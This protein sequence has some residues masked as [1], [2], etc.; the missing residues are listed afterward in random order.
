MRVDRISGRKER[1]LKH[2]NPSRTKRSTAKRR[3]NLA[4]SP[5]YEKAAQSVGISVVRNRD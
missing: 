3:T 2:K 1:A 5:W 4:T